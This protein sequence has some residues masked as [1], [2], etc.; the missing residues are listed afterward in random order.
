VGSWRGFFSPGAPPAPPPPG[1]CG[2]GGGGGPP[3]RGVKRRGVGVLT[4][5]N[6]PETTRTKVSITSKTIEIS[7][8]LDFGKD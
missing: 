6:P 1:R 4:K 3:P 7:A 8:L 5:R 2:G